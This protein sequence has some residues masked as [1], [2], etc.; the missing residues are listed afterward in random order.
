MNCQEAQAVLHAY[1]DREL[2]PSVSLQYEQHM[3]ECP[4]CGKALAEHQAMRSALHAESLYFPAPAELRERL[5]SSLRPR[6]GRRWVGRPWRWLAVAACMAL[7]AGLGFL[8]ARLLIAPTTHERLIGEVAAA[9]IR[10][11]QVEHLVDVRSSD[12]HKVKPWFSGKLN[13]APPTLDLSGDNF[14]LEGG[15]LDYLDGRLVAAVVYR[16]RDH[17]INVFVWSDPAAELRD[18]RHDTRQGYQLFSWST[19][20][21]NYWVVSDLDPAELRELVQRLRE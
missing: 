17:P 19:A 7:C 14:P 10:S 12:R 9:H 8:A 20:G 18:V 21:M 1:L 13:F 3:R 4:T 15:R 16:R 5:R 6:R 11:L 2:D